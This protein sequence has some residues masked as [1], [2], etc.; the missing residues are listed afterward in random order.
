[1]GFF[2][3]FKPMS[4]EMRVL[5]RLEGQNKDGRIN[6]KEN[7]IVFRKHGIKIELLSCRIESTEQRYAA[8]LVFRLCSDELE[9]P[10]IEPSSSIAASSEEALERAADQFVTVMLTFVMSFECE[11]MQQLEN[12]FDGRK[13]IY[14]YPC[15]LPVSVLGTTEGRSMKP[16]EIVK[17]ELADYLGGRKYNWVKLFA[18]RVNEKTECEARVNGILIPELSGKLTEYVQQDED[19]NSILFEKQCILFVQDKETFRPLRHTPD[20]V[21]KY[22]AKA[23]PIIAEIHDDESWERGFDRIFA[24]SG[25]GYL[26]SEL[27]RFLPEIVALYCYSFIKHSSD[28]TLRIGEKELKIKKQQLTAWCACE[29]AVQEM[30]TVKGRDSEY[31][32]KIMNYGSSYYSCMCQLAEKYT[33]EQLMSGDIT[34]TS[35]DCPMPDNYK[36]YIF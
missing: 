10:I 16:F 24:L 18:G 12:R 8:H 1:M 36:E 3:R 19:K 26:T 14:H 28:I 29:N 27:I 20:E 35:L 30:L 25:D 33:K 9:E 17:N 21:K 13:H 22:A 7:S 23:L 15:T 34:F 6:E 5:K 4:N 11:E 31:L 32:Y 2:D